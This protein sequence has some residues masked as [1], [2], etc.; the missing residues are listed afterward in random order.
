LFSLSPAFALRSEKLG[1]RWIQRLRPGGGRGNVVHNPVITAPLLWLAVSKLRR[2][3]FFKVRKL[4]AR[5][6]RL[7][8]PKPLEENGMR[9]CVCVWRSPS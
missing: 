6:R 7:P 3:G 5:Q 9:V 4:L 8:L 2:A 1:L